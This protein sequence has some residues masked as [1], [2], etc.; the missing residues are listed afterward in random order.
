MASV[1]WGVFSPFRLSTNTL[2]LHYFPIPSGVHI[3]RI[4]YVSLLSVS[5]EREY[6][7]KAAG[8]HLKIGHLHIQMLNV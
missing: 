2:S 7:Q 4:A 5:R 1:L 6:K 3:F 8:R